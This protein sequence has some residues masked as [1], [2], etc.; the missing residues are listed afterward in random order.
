MAGEPWGVS[1]KKS[2]APEFESETNQVLAGLDKCKSE[3]DVVNLISRV[4][5]DNF[6]KEQFS[7]ESCKDVGKEVYNWYNYL[8][9]NSLFPCPCCGYKTLS[10]S[11]SG[12]YEI[13]EICFWEDD[14]AGC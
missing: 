9:Q 4:F 2:I 7:M 10:E 1:T 13:C 12:T 5:T 6:E 14:M 8:T 3:D 11:A